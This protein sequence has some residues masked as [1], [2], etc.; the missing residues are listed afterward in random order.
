PALMRSTSGPIT[1]PKW[2]HDPTVANVSQWASNNLA[3]PYR[4]LKVLSFGDG[5]AGFRNSPTTQVA[6]Y[7]SSWRIFQHIYLSFYLDFLA[8][9]FSVSTR[10]FPFGF[11]VDVLLIRANG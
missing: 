6:E 3:I 10:I 4:G 11:I 5:L 2:R 8:P 7:P 9:A 1:P